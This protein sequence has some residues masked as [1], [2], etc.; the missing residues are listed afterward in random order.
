MFFCKWHHDYHIIYITNKYLANLYSDK[1][2]L[3][4]FICGTE[5]TFPNLRGLEKDLVFAY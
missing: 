1:T 4:S 5:K 3:I 2:I